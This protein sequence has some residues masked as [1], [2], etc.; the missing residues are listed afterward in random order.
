MQSRIAIDILKEKFP[1][2][3]GSDFSMILSTAEGSTLEQNGNS[4]VFIDAVLEF[5]SVRGPIR[6]SKS[7]NDQV[8]RYEFIAVGSANDIDNQN[9]IHSL[10]DKIIPELKSK[11]GMS[12]YLS[13]TLPYVVDEMDRYSSRTPQVFAAVLLLSFVFLLVAFRSIVVP[14]KAILL[15]I[16]STA[17]AFGVLTLVFEFGILGVWHYGVIEAFVPALLYSILFGLSMDYHVL[18]LSRVQEEVMHGASTKEA[19]RKA[20]VNTAPSITSAALIMVSV[21]VIIASLE[22][23]LMKELGLGLAVAITVDATII[24]IVL[25]PATMVLLNRWNWYLPGWLSWIPKVKI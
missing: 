2:M 15:N 14:L 3:A 25:L 20:V 12:A 1:S 19:V 5:E 18:L 8:A 7:D 13:G 6:L 17:A 4:A 10:R 23:P 11:T 16:L 24:R 9:L 22:L 21:F